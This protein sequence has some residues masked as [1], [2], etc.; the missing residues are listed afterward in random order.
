MNKSMAGAGILGCRQRHLQAV[1]PA[2]CDRESSHEHALA[3]AQ[4][5]GVLG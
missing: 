3:S 5:A 4:H 2:A 1:A